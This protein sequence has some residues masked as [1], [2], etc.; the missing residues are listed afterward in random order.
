MEALKITLSFLVIKQL[1]AKL[2]LLRKNPLH[3]K[4]SF[5][6]HFMIF[7]K[8]FVYRILQNA[9]LTFLLGTGTVYP[10][11]HYTEIVPSVVTK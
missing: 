3:L 2:N 8:G 7:G 10:N 6:R 1:S 4:G 5:H 11:F 9:T